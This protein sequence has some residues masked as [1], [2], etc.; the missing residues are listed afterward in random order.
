VLFDR[1]IQG[2]GAAHH[3]IEPPGL[4]QHVELAAA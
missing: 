2:R 1:G 3:Q 4:A